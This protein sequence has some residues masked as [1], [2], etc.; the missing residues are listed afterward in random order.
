M[1]VFTRATSRESARPGEWWPGAGGVTLWCPTCG[2]PSWAPHAV[3]AAGNLSP[4]VECPYKD[5]EA[6]ACGFHV[7]ARLEGYER[8]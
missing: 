8:G 5:L 3:D 7:M 2:R 6:R 1:T 4:S